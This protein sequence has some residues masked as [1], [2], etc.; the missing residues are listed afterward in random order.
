MNM[1]DLSFGVEGL[2]FS[3]LYRYKVPILNCH[4]YQDHNMQHIYKKILVEMERLRRQ[5]IQKLGRPYKDPE[6]REFE[7]E[8]M[9]FMKALD[10]LPPS[11]RKQWRQNVSEANAD[12]IISGHKLAT[13]QRIANR[14]NNKNKWVLS[15]GLKARNQ[16]QTKA[17]QNRISAVLEA[18]KQM[19]LNGEKTT[20]K[21]VLKRIQSTS[22]DYES[23]Q[24][25]TIRKDIA[26]LKKAAYL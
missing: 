7:Y 11:D 14:K 18:I 2:H 25:E 20:S 9:L 12:L 26:K 16:E 8:A 3:I 5:G 6:V 1:E 13:S 10:A 24:S 22:S 17:M 19:N 4:K 23:I 15:K 21:T